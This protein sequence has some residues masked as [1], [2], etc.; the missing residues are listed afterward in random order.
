MQIYLNIDRLKEIKKIYIIDH[1]LYRSFFYLTFV[2][3]TR[4]RNTRHSARGG[5][6][7]GDI[8]QTE[9]S[10]KL[11]DLEFLQIC[12]FGQNEDTTHRDVLETRN[13]GSQRPIYDRQTHQQT[14]R[15]IPEIGPDFLVALDF[16]G[17]PNPSE[18]G[19]SIVGILA[20]RI[21]PSI[22]SVLSI[23]PRTHHL[24]VS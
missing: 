7:W 15:G 10:H 23:F 8:K 3:M 22:S 11:R 2:N 16:E 6:K 9:Y 13:C 12:L 21:L 24:G 17:Q 4:S 19:V 18:M 1:T 5:S 20:R 14:G